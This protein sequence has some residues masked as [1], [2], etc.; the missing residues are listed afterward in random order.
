MNSERVSNDD[1]TVCV[2][3]AA[4]YIRV[5]YPHPHVG[6]A[7]ELLAAHPEL[8]DLAGP[9]PASALWVLLLVA[10]QFALAVAAGQFP[11]YVW[12]PSAY[13]AGATIDHALWVLIHDCAHNLV[14]PWRLGNRMVALAANLPMVF[15]AAMSFCRY[16][17][18]HHSHLGDPEFDADVPGPTE[19]RVVGESP[20]AKGLWL[21]TFSF[22][23]GVIR[24]RRLTRVPQV[25]RWM[26]INVVVQVAA[27]AAFVEVAGWTPLWYL[28][29]SAVF[30]IGL[31]PLGARWIAEHYVFT[32]GQETYSV[33]RAAQQGRLQYRLPQRTSRSRQHSLGAP[34][35]GPHART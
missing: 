7:R 19:A 30:A 34:A 22:V 31:H 6:R 14:L 2:V 20:L 15:P 17:L 25:D 11:W 23:M 12:L 28:V 3:P 33:L 5:S 29:A 4:D 35:A 18:L 13:L 26:A 9:L 8:R 16:H 21:A 32:P 24:P 1:A 10:A 27:M